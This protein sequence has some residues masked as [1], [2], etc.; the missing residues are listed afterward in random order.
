MSRTK[1]RPET[2]GYAFT[3]SWTFDSTE[4][5][6]L[7]QLVTDA[8]GVIEV[9]LSP[10]IAA[11]LGPVIAAE[12]GVPFIGPWLVYETIKKAND[13][14]VNAIVGAIDAKPYG[15]CGG[16]AFS[17]LDYFLKGWIVPRGNGTNDQPQRTSPTGTALRNYIWNRLIKS[18]EDN[19]GTF[20]QWMAVLHFDGGPGATWLKDQSHAQLATLKA[21]IDAGTP[22]TLGLIGTTWNPM[23]NHQVL[24]Y[25][26]QN[27]GDGTTTL[28]LYDNNAPG[29]ES[30]T[31]L[32]FG[33]SVLHATES[34]SSAARG[35]LRGFFCTH[36][37]PQTPPRAVV[38]RSG[39]T[40]SPHSTGMDQPVSVQF[41]AANIGFHNSPQFELV[42]A[43]NTGEVAKEASLTSIAEGAARQLSSHLSFHLSG[44]H[45]VGVVALL[46]TFGGIQVTK[47]LPPE[48]NTQHPTADVVVFAERNIRAVTHSTCESTNTVGELVTFTAAASDMG[49]GAHYQWTVT[50][51]A[52]QGSSTAS[53]IDV[54]LPAQVGASVTVSLKVSLPDGAFSTG[55][56]SFQTVSQEAAGIQYV[57]CE[58]S[59]IMTKQPIKFDPGDPAIVNAVTQINPGD[60][61]AIR[62]VAANVVTAANA[63]LKTNAPLTLS[64]G[65]RSTLADK[66]SA[67]VAK[68]GV[69]VAVPVVS[70]I[71]A[72]VR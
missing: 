68:A 50:G 7:T 34:C 66:L 49:A 69:G 10:F 56:Y 52:I 29:V 70:A 44:T 63:A 64:P 45:H 38:L 33:G 24:C 18:I 57:L 19:V 20:L 58:L 8:V 62:D 27:N 72:K 30:T 60:L 5:A 9:V 12:A 14:I 13:A 71:T 28:F 23:D 55:S 65:V 51:G 54:K 6:T 31:R 48:G 22:V 15:L 53:Q 67:Q 61:T 32:D 41:S 11:A 16:M 17:S 3:N 2:D 46:G 36:Y 25:G 59:H 1:F 4:I 47:Q 37:T 43:A 42:A 21:R 35:P 40:I 39:L 26:Y